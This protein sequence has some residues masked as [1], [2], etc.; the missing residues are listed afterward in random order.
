MPSLTLCLF[1]EDKS[2]IS[3]HFPGLFFFGIIPI[4][5]VG[6]L[7]GKIYGGSF[8]IRPRDSS[9]CRCSE[10]MLGTDD[11]MLPGEVFSWCCLLKP[12]RKP[13][14][15]PSTMYFTNEWSGWLAR[16]AVHSDRMSGE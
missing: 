8:I 10:I 7:R 13:F 15:I 11:G 16:S 6:I 4:G 1:G 9:L 14:W 2:T 3:R 5:L 12:I